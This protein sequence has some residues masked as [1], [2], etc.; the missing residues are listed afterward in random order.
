M[1][2]FLQLSLVLLTDN[3]ICSSCNDLQQKT[4]MA[5]TLTCFELLSELYFYVMI[6]SI[7]FIIDWYAVF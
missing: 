2:L 1:I 3:P 4:T 7:P 6:Y 5:N